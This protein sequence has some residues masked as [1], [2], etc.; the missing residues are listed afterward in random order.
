M[1]LSTNSLLPSLVVDTVFVV[2]VV[3]ASVN[4]VAVDEAVV[5]V[6]VVDVTDVDIKAVD[7][8]VVYCIFVPYSKLSAP[9]N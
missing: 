5:D 4:V 7:A 9:H 6:V 1:S 3:D 2:V 8:V